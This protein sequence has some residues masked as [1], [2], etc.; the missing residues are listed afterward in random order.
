[1]PRKNAFQGGSGVFFFFFFF[2]ESTHF[3]S[4]P[5][6]KEQAEVNCFRGGAAKILSDSV[7]V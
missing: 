5:V 1:M 3:L 2:S 7:M 6:V 4:T